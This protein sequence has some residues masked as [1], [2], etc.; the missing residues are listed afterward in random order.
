VTETIFVTGANGFLGSY[1]C[2][3]LL[4]DSDAHLML[5]VRGRSRADQLARLW[6]TWQL[7]LSV[8]AFAAV[9]PRLTLLSG[10]LHEPALG[11]PTPARDAL[12][13]RVTSILHIAASL[14]RKSE[15]ACLNTN[16]RG[17]LS[18][19]QLARHLKDHGRLHRFSHVS[20]VAVAGHRHR[21]VVEEDAAI[22]WERSD[23]DPYGRTKKFC[24][25]MVRELLP[26]VRRLWF[27]PSIV[28]GDARFPMTTQFDMVRAFCF[29]A[30]LPIIP[31]DPDARQDI[32]NA[33]YVGRAIATIHLKPQPRWDTYH[34]SSGQASRSARAIADALVAHT[35]RRARFRGRLASPFSQVIR[36]LDQAPRGTTPAQIGALLKVFWPYVTWDTVFANDRVRAELGADPTPFPEYC[37]GLYDWAHAQGF[38][39]PAVALPE[40]LR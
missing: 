19:V 14:N 23:Y 21:E 18:V 25:H 30:D 1:A 32:V 33:D 22:D 27:R 5:L 16:L 31:L 7:H 28:M 3:R 8:D 36:V 11:L 9:L 13:E 29:I 26:D 35:G 2:A 24:E 20:T 12:R 39:Y 38:R 37:A 15:K 40:S 6:A 17:T 4:A 34:L 10:D